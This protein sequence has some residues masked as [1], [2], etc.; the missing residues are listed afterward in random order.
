MKYKLRVSSS[1]IGFREK[2][3][4]IWKLERYKFPQDI[5]KPVVFFGL[6]HWVDYLRF[7]I[8]RGKKTIAWCGSDILNLNKFLTKLFQAKHYCENEVERDKLRSVGISAEIRPTFLEDVND[9]PI[10]YKQS[11][12]PQVFI[13]TREGREKE[14]G[15]NLIYKI[16]GGLPHIVFHIYGLSWWTSEMPIR[17]NVIL[18]GLVS[19]KQFNEEIKN[20]QAGLRLNE[21]DGF[22]EVLAKSILSGQY[23][24][25]RIKYPMIDNYETEEEL[26]ALLKDLKNKIEPNY[27]A[28]EF[29]K[30][31]VNKLEFLLD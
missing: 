16:A 10:T 27:K 30:N 9:F 24:I 14:Y 19:E 13:S 17:K 18:H 29:W 4:R 23:P 12:R 6:Y 20:Y 15:V 26:V 2:A 22:S 11:R 31:Y 5:F 7:I 8:H 3:E 21:F 1:V 25:S 28:R